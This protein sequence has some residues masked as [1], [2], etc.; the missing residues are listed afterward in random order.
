[1]YYFA[2]QKSIVEKKLINLFFSFQVRMFYPSLKTS[3][4][5]VTFVISITCLSCTY[6]FMLYLSIHKVYLYVPTCLIPFLCFALLK[7]KT[8]T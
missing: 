3:N 2:C 1:M 4:G 7:R 8:D 6:E 5:N